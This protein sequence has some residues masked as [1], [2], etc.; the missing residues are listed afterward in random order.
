MKYEVV[1]LSEKTVAGLKTRTSNADP[2][3]T[4][5][6]GGL[7]QKFFTEGVY[8]S[9]PNKQ[10]AHSIGLY[11]NYETNAHGA[12][13]VMVC[14]EISSTENLP[15]TINAQKI[16]A[17]N[18]AKFIVHGDVQKA[19]SEFWTKLWSMDLDRKYSCDFEEYQSS[20]DMSNAEIHIYISLK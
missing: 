3:M 20:C 2:T 11:T 9:I 5:T 12:Y 13:D 10:N 7:W 8:Q 16:P 4:K 6:I 17:G 14:C 19:V 1:T 15:A 18:Y